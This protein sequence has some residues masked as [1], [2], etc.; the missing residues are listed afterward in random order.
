MAFWFMLAERVKEA[1]MGFW[2]CWQ[3][4]LRGHDGVLVLLAE[5]VKEAMMTFWFCWQK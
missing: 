3:K 1:M 5:R 2:F 4:G